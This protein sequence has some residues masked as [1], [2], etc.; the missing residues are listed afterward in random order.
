M[1]WLRRVMY[2]RYGM[3]QLGMTLVG[4]YLVFYLL[5]ALFSSHMLGILSFLCLIFQVLRMF[6]KRIDK[7]RA[8][9]ERFM[10]AIGP[11]VRKYNVYKCRRRD[12]EHT[13]FKCPGCGQQLRAPKGKG[14]I[15][16]ICRSCG[17]SFE[18]KT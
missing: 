1:N 12:K 15:S 2:G 3:D 6:S 5:S 14:K 16:V 8:E 11:F 13:Y 17:A 4:G 18:K 9:N 10:G 7:R